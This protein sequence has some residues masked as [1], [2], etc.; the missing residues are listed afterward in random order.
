MT[1]LNGNVLMSAL[2][3]IREG[4]GMGQSSGDLKRKWDLSEEEGKHDQSKEQVQ[5]VNNK[6][7]NSRWK[8]ADSKFKTLQCQLFKGMCTARL[9]PVHG[10]V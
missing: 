7:R 2:Y 9:S 4:T 3:G 10:A 8:Q 6:A 5:S 1:H